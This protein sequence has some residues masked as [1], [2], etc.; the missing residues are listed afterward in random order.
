MRA[1]EAEEPA[2]PVRARVDRAHHATVHWLRRGLVQ[3]RHPRPRQHFLVR[4]RTRRC[5]IVE[6]GLLVRLVVGHRAF[7]AGGETASP[8]GRRLNTLSATTGLS[9][10][11]S[12]Y[13]N[14]DKFPG[15]S[16]SLSSGDLWSMLAHDLE[17]TIYMRGNTKC[18]RRHGAALRY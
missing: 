1:R 3:R 9:R 6:I 2:E 4:N 8:D 12:D 17:F 13:G 11:L 5:G 16:L 15:L 10:E 18:E 14:F 7:D